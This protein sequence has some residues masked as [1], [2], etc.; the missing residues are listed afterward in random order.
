MRT[1]LGRTLLSLFFVVAAAEI[2]G[3][4]G[5]A[6]AQV[7]AQ[8][9]AV[10]K[11]DTKA[12]AKPLSR[13]ISIGLSSAITSMD[14][15]YHNLIP[16]NGV[17][18]HI[19]DSLIRQDAS[20]SLVPGLAKSWRAIDS[21]TW[22]FKLR[23]G[24]R[25]H[26]GHEFTAEDVAFTIKRAPNVPNSPASFA[27]YLKAITAVEIVD[28]YTLVLRTAVPS[29]LLPNDIATV[30]IVSKKVGQTATT[31]DYNSGKAAIGTGPY[32]F[33][34]YVPNQQIVVK[35]NYAY[36][37]GEEPWDKVT[38]KMLTNPATRVAALLSGDVA[39]IEGVPTQDQA[40]LA[41]DKR[42]SLF[43]KVSNRIIYLHLDSGRKTRS[44]YTF[45]KDGKPLEK[46]PLAD[47]RVRRALSL[48][49]DRAAIVSRI[50]DGNAIAAGQLLADGF[51][52]VSKI[53]KP[54][55]PDPAQAK[56]LLSDAGYPD[57]FRLTL[58]GPAGRYI[59]DDKIVQAVAQ[60]LTRIGVDTRVETMP[61]S[62]FFSRGSRL[63][64]S[65]IMVGW[66]A[67]TGEA[68]S[69]LRALLATYDTATGMGVANRGRY[70]NRELD[71]VLAQALTT[72]DDNKR[73]VLLAQ[74]TELGIRDTG[75]IPLHYEI[76]TW[77]TRS[78]LRYAGRADQ[79]TLAM[80]LRPN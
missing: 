17:L 27:T 49:I 14:P 76:S 60:M 9:P 74:A 59:N 69:P 51:F 36:W 3:L 6:K 77:A 57:G 28:P 12:D 21:T 38:F 79:Y 64:F 45:D 8:A 7:H 39:F 58:H 40:N 71:R 25:W 10:I 48:A 73:A 19:Y 44:P 15:H 43:N 37:A 24:V 54:E 72:I 80:D 66:G 23:R 70:S 4:A 52:G 20:Q 11:T 41:K 46:N 47:A 30:L 31:E 50:M 13:E 16:N 78:G 56:K 63:E 67:E 34:G 62:V 68:S 29:P 42:F 61:P 2:S 32:K 75:L 1:L 55:K 65:F 33:V 53:L 5:E 35:A 22:E 26:D 18:R